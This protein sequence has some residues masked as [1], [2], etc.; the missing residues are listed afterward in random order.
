MKKWFHSKY[1]CDRICSS[2]FKKCFWQNNWWLHVTNAKRDTKDFCDALTLYFGYKK[3][4]Q[5]QALQQPF[6]ISPLSP[7][8]LTFAESSCLYTD[9]R[10]FE[11]SQK[12]ESRNQSADSSKACGRFMPGACNVS[13]SEV[14]NY[15]VWRVCT[16]LL[17]ISFPFHTVFR[18]KGDRRSHSLKPAKVTLF[19][20]IL[21]NSENKIR[22]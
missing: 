5:S 10:K 7:Q 20:I 9:M 19:T 4:Q 1:V 11:L 3:S 21:Y 14:V 2:C 15:K 12:D 6:K 8:I 16:P 13:H 22:K 18:P 17:R